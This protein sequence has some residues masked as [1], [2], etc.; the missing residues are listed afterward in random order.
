MAL[1]VAANNL[2]KTIASF[3]PE[4]PSDIPLLKLDQT[5]LDFGKVLY[6]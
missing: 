5:S 6:V 1:D 3:D 4:K 2:Y